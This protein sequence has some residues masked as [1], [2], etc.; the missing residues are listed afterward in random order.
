[1]EVYTILNCIRKKSTSH[2]NGCIVCTAEGGKC[3]INS[4]RSFQGQLVKGMKASESGRRISIP[5]RL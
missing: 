2:A 1:M 5:T 3:R 4:T